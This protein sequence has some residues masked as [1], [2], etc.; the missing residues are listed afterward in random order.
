MYA[1]LIHCGTTPDRRS[2]LDRVIRDRLLPAL[3]A[4]PG[5]V[6]TLNLARPTED[7]A[8]LIVLW[9]SREHAARPLSTRSLELRRALAAI[10]ALANECEERPLVWEF[11]AQV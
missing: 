11:A 4:D 10:T 7:D 1:Q 9:I 8:M 3:L 2:E 6:G 5:F